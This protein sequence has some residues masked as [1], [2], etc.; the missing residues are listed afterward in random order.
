MPSLLMNN[1]PVVEYTFKTNAKVVPQFPTGFVTTF[2]D[3]NNGD[4]TSTRTYI[5]SEGEFPTFIKFGNTTNSNTSLL[6]VERYTL[7]DKKP[8]TMESAFENCKALKSINLNNINSNT[9]TSFNKSFRYNESLEYLDISN[10]NI[11]NVTDFSYAFTHSKLKE[12]KLP[13]GGDKITTLTQCFAYTNT[14]SEIDMS[15]MNLPNVEEM[16][17]TFAY[18]TCGDI[19]LP[20]DLGN[21]GKLNQISSLCYNSTISSI[22]ISNMDITGLQKMNY[23]FYGCNISE[24]DFSGWTGKGD[25][26]I[27]MGATFGKCTVSELNCPFKTNNVQNFNQCFYDLPNLVSLDISTWDT[28]SCTDFAYCFSSS[29]LTTINFPTKL[30]TTKGNSLIEMFANCPASNIPVSDITTDVATNITGMLMGCVGLSGALDLRHF[31]LET[32]LLKISNFLKGCTN[33]THVY[34]NGTKSKPSNTIINFEAISAFENMTSLEELD[35]SNWELSTALPDSNISSFLLNV[36]STCNVK[37]SANLG[38][39]E[40]QLSFSGNF[41][42]V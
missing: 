15:M 8:S 14:L 18:I 41:T 34:L 26:L 29:K 21:N 13:N 3:I 42:V 23:S 25:N 12:I 30:N 35:I 17:G 19:I 24:L 27:Q 38:K 20:N 1:V 37:V 11:D 16:V 32:S 7:T 31:D 5:N 10:V 6:S 4:G 36:P 2:F 22:N 33:V 39:T 40:S 9:I 28:S